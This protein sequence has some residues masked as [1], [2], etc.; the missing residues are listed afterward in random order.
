MI[1]KFVAELIMVAFSSWAPE[2]AECFE[3]HMSAIATRTTMTQEQVKE[4]ADGFIYLPPNNLIKRANS[5]EHLV[6]KRTYEQ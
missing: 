5:N 3:K 6:N 4:W 2:R 1:N